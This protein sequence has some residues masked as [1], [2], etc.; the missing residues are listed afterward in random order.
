MVNHSDAL[1]THTELLDHMESVMPSA[2][3]EKFFKVMDT[4]PSE[5]LWDTMVDT[6]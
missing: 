5:T 6:F 2:D 3:I 1:L 4:N